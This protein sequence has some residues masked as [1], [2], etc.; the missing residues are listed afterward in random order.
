MEGSRSSSRSPLPTNAIGTPTTETTES[1]APP[2]ASPSSFVST[3]PVTP[4]RAVELA[5][6]LDRVLPRHRVG[7]VEQVRRID[8][9]LDRLE[10]RH[11]RIVDVQTARRV[12]DER[13]RTRVFFASGS[14]PVRARPDRVRPPD[15]ARASS[16]CCPSTFNCW[17]AAGRRTSV[18]TSI[19][20]RPCLR[21][22]PSELPRRRRLAGALEPEQHHHARA[23]ASSA[24]PP[25]RI[26][27]QRQHLV[28]HDRTTCCDGVRLRRTS[29]SIAR[30]RT[31]SMNA[32]TTLKLTSASSSASRISRSAASTFVSVRRPSP[33]IDSEDVLQACAERVEH[34]RPNDPD[35]CMRSSTRTR[36]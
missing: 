24:S 13:R 30:S 5:G 27:E 7:D 14:A 8:G 18:E 23:A 10:L 4:T 21:Q 19:G 29:W 6:A 20:W 12:D 1:A 26:A 36:F 2:R 3:T 11:Q 35:Y 34:H 17:M 16:A 9:R 32:L 25:L 22:P 31:R 15:R 33:R 28:A